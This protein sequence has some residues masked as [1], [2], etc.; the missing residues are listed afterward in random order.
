VHAQERPRVRH[1]SQPHAEREADGRRRRGAGRLGHH[2]ASRCVCARRAIRIVIQRSAIERTRARAS[3]HLSP[4]SFAVRRSMPHSEWQSAAHLRR[5]ERCGRCSAASGPFRPP[6]DADDVE[7]EIARLRCSPTIGSTASWQR[8]VA[9]QRRSAHDEWGAL[10]STPASIREVQL[11][12]PHP[13]NGAPGPCAP[14]QVQANPPRADASPD[15]SSATLSRVLIGRAASDRR[16]CTPHRSLPIHALP[17]VS[18][19]P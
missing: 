14:L 12:R 3:P 18:L 1:P 5:H 4:G 13:A 19:L 6:S 7:R 10:S 9:A 17:G 8:P 11:R 16:R 2:G 15:V